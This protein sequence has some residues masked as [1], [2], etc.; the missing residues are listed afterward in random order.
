MIYSIVREFDFNLA[1][2]TCLSVRCLTPGCLS[3]S[4]VMHELQIS[5]QCTHSAWRGT[6]QTLSLSC[7]RYSDRKS[8]LDWSQ[9]NLLQVNYRALHSWHR[10]VAL[11]SRRKSSDWYSTLA[12]SSGNL[13]CGCNRTGKSQESNRLQAAYTLDLAVDWSLT[14]SETLLLSNPI[15]VS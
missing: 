14:K 10:L 2:T 5:P 4:S 12:R 3:F 9:L 15:S 8:L 7:S 11:V 6:L 1:F 13:R